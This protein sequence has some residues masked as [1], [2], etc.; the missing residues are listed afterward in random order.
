M[1][2]DK[3]KN[4]W[5]E[6]YVEYWKTRVVES[7][8]KNQVSSELVKNDYIVPSDDI[9]LDLLTRCDFKNGSVLDVG[10][11]WGRL[12]PLLSS[13]AMK[14]YGIDISRQMV[15]QARK[16]SIKD[17]V[18]IKESCAEEIPYSDDFFDFLICFGVFDATFQ[19]KAIS[20]FLRVLKI[21]GILIITGKNN[22]YH[23][24]DR[25]AK[26]AEIGALNKGEP[27]YFT[28]V[29]SM[30]DQISS[31]G[32]EI[33]HEFYFERRGDFS[34]GSYTNQRPT[35]FYEYCLSIK[36]KNQKRGF[37]SFSHKFSLKSGS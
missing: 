31:L 36:K 34:K 10:C 15:D 18:E 32:H 13:L 14:I 24:D 19:D 37:R 5:D 1:P 21:G 8:N 28:D 26:L 30:S 16:V 20:E 33:V 3:R 7:E 27:N 17:V 35:K 12:F 4:Y 25:E 11:A 23:P 22:A 29:Q 6:K 2:K 9:Y